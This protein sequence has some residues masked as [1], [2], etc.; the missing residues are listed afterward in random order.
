MIRRT[1]SLGV[2]T[3]AGFVATACSST[4]TSPTAL[5][6]SAGTSVVNGATSG[7]PGPL[8]ATAVASGADLQLSGSAS[9]GSPNPGAAFTYT[10]Q[11]KNSGPE[12]AASTVFSDTLPPDATY[13]STAVAGASATCSAAPDTTG[14]STAV[15]C[16]LG[17]IAKG[18]QATVTISL[19][20]PVTA[21][22][23]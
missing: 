12:A 1:S 14:N 9:T 15:T 22:T 18:A 5:P 10:F 16:N 8:A 4:A 6:Q 21:G 23:V 11:V 3:L 13:G 7:G 17:T 20:A 2:V 19:Y